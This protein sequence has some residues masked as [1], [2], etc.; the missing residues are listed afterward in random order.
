MFSSNPQHLVKGKH[1]AKLAKL[2][3]KSHEQVRVEIAQ[4]CGTS[5]ADEPYNLLITL[6]KDPSPAV[7]MA[8]IRSL[9][10][11]GRPAAATHLQ[12]LSDHIPAD[13]TE[14]HALIHDAL[15]KIR[16]RK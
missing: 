15:A 6:T 4:A 13:R 10:E 9:G 1:W 2:A 14:E 3:E 11:V 16:E 5:T 8:A 12:W 7:Q